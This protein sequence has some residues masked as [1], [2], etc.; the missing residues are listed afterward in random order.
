M[1][2]GSEG[3]KN[4]VY[5]RGCCNHAEDRDRDVRRG[6]GCGWAKV[7]RSKSTGT[8]WGMSEKKKPTMNPHFLT[9]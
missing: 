4:E 6:T 2:P 5:L 3:N 1:K 8:V 9:G 7:N